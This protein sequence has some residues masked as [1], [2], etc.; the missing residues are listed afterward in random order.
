MGRAGSQRKCGSK[1]VGNRSQE[2]LLEEGEVTLQRAP[3]SDGLGLSSGFLLTSL[4]PACSL[5]SLRLT[6]L[7]LCSKASHSSLLP[8][9]QV[10]TGCLPPSPE[11]QSS[12]SVPP[13]ASNALHP[14]KLSIFPQTQPPSWAL[15]LK[16]GSEAGSPLP[17]SPLLLCPF[18]SIPTGQTLPLPQPPPSSLQPPPIHGSTLDPFLPLPLP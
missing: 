17:S 8:S 4:C 6:L 15:H 7:L 5:R 16:C 9:G 12:I 18:L 11:T 3:T 1:P 14:T 13:R 2:D 10:L